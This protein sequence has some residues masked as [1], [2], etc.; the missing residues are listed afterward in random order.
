MILFERNSTATTIA[1]KS[2]SFNVISGHF[3]TISSAQPQDRQTPNEN[4]N[5]KNSMSPTNRAW[6]LGGVLSS[7]CHRV[8]DGEMGNGGTVDSFLRLGLL[9]FDPGPFCPWVGRDN[10]IGKLEGQT[11]GLQS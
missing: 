6:G 3:E 2:P 5:R 11:Q 8:P 10:T 9:Q 4:S 7:G 1:I